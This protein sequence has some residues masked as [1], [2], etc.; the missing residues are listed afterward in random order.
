MNWSGKSW[1]ASAWKI[2]GHVSVV[3]RRVREGFGRQ[4][5]PQ[6]GAAR[7]G[8]DGGQ[9]AVVVIRIGDGPNAVVVLGGGA[10]HG[11]PADVDVL[12]D[13]LAV[14][15]PGQCCRKRVQ[16]HGDEIDGCQGRAPPAAPGGWRG[17][18]G[19]EFRHESPGAA[20]SRGR[21]ASRASPS[22]RR[23]TAPERRRRA[24]P[25]PCPTR[26]RSPSQG[27]PGR[28]PAAR[29]RACRIRPTA[30]VVRSCRRHRRVNARDAVHHPHPPPRRT[31]AALWDKCGVPAPECAPRAYPPCHRDARAR[32]PAPRSDRY[33]GPQ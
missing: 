20:S 29:C 30:R 12:D 9:H 32:P 22:P 24:A 11:R 13:L 6:I 26:P 14:V 17:R 18:V 33:P 5:A 31:T 2:P 25:A 3:E 15:R 27:R 21:R 7:T 8:L 4:L 10:N 1:P 28:R 16:V 23:S 19:P